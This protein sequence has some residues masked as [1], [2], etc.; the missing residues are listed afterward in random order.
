MPNLVTHGTCGK[1]WNQRGNYTSHCPKCHETMS[2]MK[3]FD[4]H[5]T[6]TATGSVLCRDMS[7][8]AGV[9]VL[10]GV[11]SGPAIEAGESRR[12]WS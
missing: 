3:L 9:R 11:W 1:Q 2:S 4:W 12:F 6:L 7:E 10:D 8:Y 5:Q